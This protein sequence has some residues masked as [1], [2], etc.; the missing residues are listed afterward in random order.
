MEDTLILR[1]TY[2]DIPVITEMFEDCKAYLE[3]RGI[4][5]WNEHYPSQDYFETKFEGENLFILKISGEI[6]GAMVLDEWQTA[7]WQQ[8]QWS[9]NDGKPLILHSFCVHPSA[10]GGG[11]GGKMLE[12]AENFTKE[13]GYSA[14]RLDA[15]S[16]NEA[17]VKFYEKR[18]YQ[19]TGE[20]ELSGK[21]A[22]HEKYYCFE[23]LF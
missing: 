22:G 2:E 12:F 23:K 3:Q 16:G 11:N 6:K 9:E 13:N 20:V 4:L 21:P 18:G 5:Q 19:K 1:A 15:F 10:Q 14:L 7:E 17:A 8:A